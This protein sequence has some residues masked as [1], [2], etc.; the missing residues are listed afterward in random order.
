MLAFKKLVPR[1]NQKKEQDPGQDGPSQ[2]ALGRSNK[3]GTWSSSTLNDPTHGN[4]AGSQTRYM[5]FGIGG[6]G[7]IRKVNVQNGQVV[8][9]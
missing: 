2:D 8:N 3:E 4:S 7:N 9:Q 1:K 5:G 6:A